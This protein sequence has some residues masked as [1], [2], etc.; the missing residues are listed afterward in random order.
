MQRA[1][2]AVGQPG[3]RSA[4]PVGDRG[5]VAVDV[6]H[7]VPQDVGLEEVAAVVV[8]EPLAAAAIRHHRDH[9]VRGVLGDRTVEDALHVALAHPVG[10]ITA[11]AVQQVHDGVAEPAR[12]VARREVD[13][14]PGDE[15]R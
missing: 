9:R 7:D 12:R 10:L 8:V 11:T 14:H 2:A 15:R 3:D 1:V 4:A 5:E 13:A 6:G